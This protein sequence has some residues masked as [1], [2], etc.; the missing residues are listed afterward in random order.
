VV[1]LNT[2]TATTPVTVRDP[3]LRGGDLAW[4][5]TGDRLVGM[6]NQ[7]EPDD[8]TGFGIVDAATGAVTPHWID[9]SAYDCSDCTYGWSRD[10]REVVVGIADRS[11]GEAMELVAR[12]QFFDAASGRPTRTVPIKAMPSGP[13]SWSPDGKYVIAADPVNGT[14]LWDVAKGTA[15]PFPYD[16]VWVTDELLLAPQSNGTVLTV[17]PDGEV[18][19]RTKVGGAFKGLGSVTVG[20]PD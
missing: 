6:I 15:K 10:G 13:F 4:S 5:P 17:R 7:K 11:R 9:H 20:P 8:L 2:V 14:Q 1:E 16:A 12:L 18:I 3:K 19:H